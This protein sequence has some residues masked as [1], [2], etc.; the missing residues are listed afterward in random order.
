M[1]LLLPL[2]VLLLPIIMLPFVATVE[3]GVPPPEFSLLSDFTGGK[4][5]EGFDFFTDHDPTDGCVEFLSED[6]ARAAGLTGTDATGQV[7]MRTDNTTLNPKDRSGKTARQSVRVSS[8]RAFDPKEQIDQSGTGAVMVVLDVAHM[9]TGCGVWPAFWMNSILGTWPSQGEID[10]IEGVNVNAANT[11]TLHTDNKHGGC[12]Q[13]SS[14]T[15]EFSGHW[16]TNKIGTQ[17]ATNCWVDYPGQDHNQGC[18]VGAPPTDPLGP[19]SYGAPFNAAGGGV[20][21]MLWDY[22]K[23]SGPPPMPPAVHQDGQI[24]LWYFQRE[25][26]PTD[27]LDATGHPQPPQS[28]PMGRF[29]TSEQ[30]CPAVHFN[31]QQ[32]I[33]DITLCGQWAGREFSHDC[34]AQ[35]KSYESQGM[36]TYAACEA[37]AGANP[38]AFTESSWEINSLRV[39]AT[40]AAAPAG[41][42][43]PT[44]H[45][46]DNHTW[47]AVL[48]VV[49]VVVV[50]L[51]AGLFVARQR[52][53]SGG[54]AL[55]APIND[56]SVWASTSTSTGDQ[57]GGGEGW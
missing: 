38:A 29:H 3:G 40:T 9:P 48:L 57:W 4:F 53:K 17:N 35:A 41:G 23:P 12:S 56:D 54:G 10:M 30:D 13:L 14:P 33:F 15:S 45:K 1:A 21:V 43:K 36:D 47:T 42:G 19:H 37:W 34:P 39:F 27:L 22:T 50:M 31:Q 49:A 52:L 11:Y 28:L 46:P 8:K 55:S 26:A 32:I 6:D 5:F 18:S 44:E 24:A 51:G 16:I 20:Y 7:F 2:L 25:S